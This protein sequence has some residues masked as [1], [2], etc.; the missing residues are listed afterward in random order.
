MASGRTK[1]CTP[2]SPSLQLCFTSPITVLFLYRLTLSEC[3]SKS[4]PWQA[5]LEHSEGLVTCIQAESSACPSVSV[6]SLQD[7]EFIEEGDL[8]AMRYLQEWDEYLREE[9][10][11]V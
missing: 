7:K 11:E 3:I 8:R 9:C 4:C 1:I 2:C 5:G 10:D 6:R